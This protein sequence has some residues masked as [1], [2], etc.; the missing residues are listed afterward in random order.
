MKIHV[1]YKIEQSP[2]LRNTVEAPLSVRAE[3]EK[4][5]NELSL[6]KNEGEKKDTL[7]KIARL[8]RFEK[9]TEQTGENIEAVGKILKGKTPETYLGSDLL[10]LKKRGID[11]ASL[12]LISKEKVEDDVI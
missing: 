9:L 6:A 11:I 7:R 10:S 1:F 12:V 2:G 8:E 3:L 5:R 4:L